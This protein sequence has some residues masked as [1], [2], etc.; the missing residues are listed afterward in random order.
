MARFNAVLRRVCGE[1]GAMLVDFAVDPACADAR[2]WAE[3]RVHL[4]SHGH[5]AL[6]Y[7]AAAALG[8]PGAN[9]L[10]ELDLALHGEPDDDGLPDSDGSRWLW[11][12]V[13]PWMGRRMLGRT[14]GDGRSPKHAALV[15]VIPMDR[16]GEFTAAS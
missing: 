2:S 11:T 10:G 7:R 1:T 9:E 12:H 13:R 8:V 16:S 15:P 5:R 14:A 4:S 6:S 3:D